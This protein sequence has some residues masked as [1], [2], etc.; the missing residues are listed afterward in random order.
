MGRPRQDLV[1]KDGARHIER[2][3]K[4]SEKIEQARE[5]QSRYAAERA[6]AIRA[7]VDTGMT[8]AQVARE[9]GTTF[10]AVDNILRRH[11]A[12]P[13]PDSGR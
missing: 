6:A 5:A 9:L 11:E 10:A 8:R 3:R 4:L 2:A 13:A 1:T 12:Q 7:A